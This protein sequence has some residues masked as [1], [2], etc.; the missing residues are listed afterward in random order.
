MRPDAVGAS[1]AAIRARAKSA[2]ATRRN[3]ERRWMGGVM[4]MLARPPGSSVRI[5][6]RPM[7]QSSPLFRRYASRSRWLRCRSPLRA[8]TAC[9][10]GELG[11][12][13]GHENESAGERRR[14]GGVD[15]VHE[16][17]I[18]HRADLACRLEEAA[19]GNS[20]SDVHGEEERA[21]RPKL[22]RPERVRIGDIARADLDRSRKQIGRLRRITGDAHD[23]RSALRQLAGNLQPG[24]TGAADDAVRS[25]HAVVADT[26]AKWLVL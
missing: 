5:P 19:T 25:S 7:L 10:G 23:R 3:N 21:T 15:D 4:R 13:P 22:C 14:L 6:P 2:R 20:P 18:C 9:E 24:S 16:A 8:Q 12:H 17:L 1:A 11:P 26:L